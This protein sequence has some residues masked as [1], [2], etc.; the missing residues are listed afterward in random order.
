MA[1][2]VNE[3]F[4][5]AARSDWENEDEEEEW[6]NRQD[7]HRERLI[8]RL[9]P[10]INDLIKAGLSPQE[11]KVAAMKERGLSHAATAL[12]LDIDKSTVGEY[13][14]R[15]RSK[16]KDAKMLIDA[17]EEHRIDI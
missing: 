15:V 13:V 11:A 4:E 9:K 8:S 6:E 17:F 14:R 12:A 7:Q 5:K 2:T 3:Y 1:E 16:R 10:T